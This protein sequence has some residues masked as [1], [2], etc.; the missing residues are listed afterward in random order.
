[1]TTRLGLD[2]LGGMSETSDG[3]PCFPLGKEMNA[4]EFRVLYSRVPEPYDNNQLGQYCR[5]IPGEGWRTP[6]CYVEDKH[7]YKPQRKPCAVPYCSMYNL[8]H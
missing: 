5:N 1:M 7:N 4:D 2:Y 6:S 8:F 3:L